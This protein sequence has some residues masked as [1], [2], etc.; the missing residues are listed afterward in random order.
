MSAVLKIHMKAGEKIFVNGA[1]VRA[2]RKVCLEFLNDVTF[3][4]ETHIIQKEDA[5]TPLRQLYFIVQSMLIEPSTRELAMS[6]YLPTHKAML[7]SFRNQDILEGLVA[8]RELVERDRV[9]D[10]LKRIR[11]LFSLEAEILESSERLKSD[12]KAVA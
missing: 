2:D 6:L 9:F 8:V 12:D 1:V 11:G 7:E 10:A 4:L 3:L 5:T